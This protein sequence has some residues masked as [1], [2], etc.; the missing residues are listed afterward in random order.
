MSESLSTGQSM[1]FFV[2][3]SANFAENS[4]KHKSTVPANSLKFFNADKVGGFAVV[5]ANKTQMS[6][7]FISG[8]NKELHQQVLYPRQH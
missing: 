8:D 2:V 6:L 3:G 1:D 4:Q 5:S 7:T